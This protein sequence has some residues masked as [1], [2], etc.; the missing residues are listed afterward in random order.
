MSYGLLKYIQSLARRLH[1]LRK[2]SKHLAILGTVVPLG[3]GA[4]FWLWNI[5][6]MA[7]MA[8]GAV[9]KD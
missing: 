3:G 2:P 1:G 4:Q 5:R 7:A 8:E 6:A 9:G